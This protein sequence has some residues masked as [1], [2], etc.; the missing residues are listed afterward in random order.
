MPLKQ[1]WMSIYDINPT[2]SFWDKVDDRQLYK[3]DAKLWMKQDL[4]DDIRANGLK[5]A[6]NVDASGNVKNG[7]MRYWV[8]RWLL[9]NEDDKRFLF[10]PVQRNYACGAFY[11]EFSFEVQDAPG[12]PKATQKEIDEIGNKLAVDIHKQWV[13]YMREP[14]IPHAKK[15][16]IYEVDPIDE[17]R[18][19]NFYDQQRNIWSVFL[20]PH[21]RDNKSM[22]CFGIAGKSLAVDVMIEGSDEE[23]KAYK[24]WWVKVRK[25]RKNITSDDYLSSVKKGYHG[26]VES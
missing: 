24:E 7:N 23:K 25:E 17:F 6:L 3:E 10:L 26:K 16:S 2:E 1:V 13:N 11:K 4:I 14:T 15:F 21:P 8:A 9:E 5:Y 12:V 18:M 20:Q 22:V 19:K